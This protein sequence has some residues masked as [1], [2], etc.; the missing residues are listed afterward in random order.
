MHS[1]S[2]RMLAPKQ[3]SYTLNIWIRYTYYYMG[4]Q[5]LPTFWLR[6][7]EYVGGENLQNV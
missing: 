4:Y 5:H 6:T 3:C 1:F 2:H 7:L